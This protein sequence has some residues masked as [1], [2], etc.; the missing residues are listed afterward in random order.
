MQ[1]KFDLSELQYDFTLVPPKMAIVDYFKELKVFSEFASCQ[2]DNDIKIAIL[3]TDKSS[4]FVKIKDTTQRAV[5]I[6]DFIGI[7]DKTKFNSV[8]DYTN[9]TIFLIC[10]A[11]L[12]MQNNHLFA[13]W[14]NTNQSFYMLINEMSKPLLKSEA[15]DIPKEVAMRLNIQ[16]QA[17]NIRQDLL[18]IE[19]ELFSDSAMKHAIA[20][21]KITKMRTYPEMYAISN[22]VE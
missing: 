16:K 12:Q 19:A 6:F 11:Y 14:W 5:A 3:L 20:L 21:S 8:I 9:K 7:I 18:K 17:D 13:L 4:P 1:Q 10:S 22:Q 2:D 15:K